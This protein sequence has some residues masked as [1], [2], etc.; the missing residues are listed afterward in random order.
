VQRRARRTLVGGLSE[1]I[2]LGLERP[3]DPLA[4]LGFEL[5]QGVDVALELVATG[6]EITHVGLQPAPLVL[7]DAAGGGLGLADERAGLRLRVLEHL[8]GPLLGV[9][10]GL[11][12]GALGQDQRPLERL[13]GL[14]VAGSGRLRLADA[15][16]DLAHPFRETFDRRRRP[17]E[18]L[19]DV[20]TVIAA[21]ALPNIRITQF[22]GGNIHSRPC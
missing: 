13:F 18:Q 14:A 1:R 8:P 2:E 4:V 9:G 10:D 7:G 19:V 21:E 17:L 16:G 6:G 11:V 22:L 20:V 5:L 12:G 15:L 3:A